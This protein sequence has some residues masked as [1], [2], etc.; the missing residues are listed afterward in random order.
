MAATR[1]RKEEAPAGY[2][3]VTRGPEAKVVESEDR[4]AGYAHVP[5]EDELRLVDAKSV[6]ELEVLGY[7][8]VN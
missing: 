7:R 3:W 6:P 2:V 8:V 5:G 4:E 1:K